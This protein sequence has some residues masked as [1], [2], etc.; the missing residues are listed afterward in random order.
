MNVLL[1]ITD[2]LR[3]DFVG[4]FNKRM[5]TTPFLD[6]FSRECL[7]FNNAWASSCWTIPTHFSMLTGLSPLVHGVTKRNL[8]YSGKYPTLPEILRKNGYTTIFLAYHPYLNP[9]YGFEKGFEHFYNLGFMSWHRLKY[10]IKR[11]IYGRLKKM[12]FV[13]RLSF[14]KPAFKIKAE[15]LNSYLFRI[16]RSQ[17]RNRWFIMVNYLDTHWIYY[18]YKNKFTPSRWISDEKMWEIRNRVLLEGKPLTAEEEGFFKALYANAVYYL[19]SQLQRV[20]EYMQKNKIYED[21]MIII[22]SDHG[23]MLGEKGLMDH[24][25]LYNPVIR[26]PFLVKFPGSERKGGEGRPV[27]EK[28][29]FYIVLKKL[30]VDIP[31]YEDDQGIIF[32]YFFPDEK[33]V[34]V[35]GKR[36]Q[37][38]FVACVE[39][40]WKYIYSSRFKDELYNLKEDPWEEHNLID[41]KRYEEVAKKMKERIMKKK[42][43]FPRGTREEEMDE[44]L[45]THLRG[46][47]YI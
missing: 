27:Q 31:Q 7:V 10:R 16:L 22:I 44:D 13:K 15:E 26:I 2:T 35:Y 1:I 17:Q 38:E 36:C 28:E 12:P 21:T 37:G 5:D 8:R 23:E 30:G 3:R 33:E 41:E 19:D 40:D 9:E 25:L 42:K 34:K 4:V 24:I 46:L 45:K 29:V 6:D 32:S 39:G 11:K 43:Y 14:L 18:Y 20:I 47:G